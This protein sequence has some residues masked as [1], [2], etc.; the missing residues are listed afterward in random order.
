MTTLPSSSGWGSAARTPRSNS[1]SPSRKEGAPGAG[2][3]GRARAGGGGRPGAPA[4][5]PPGGGPRPA[6]A[7]PGHEPSRVVETVEAHRLH[8]FDQARLLEGRRRPADPAPARAGGGGGHGG[9]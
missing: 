1:A 6:P 2:A 5:G 3:G 9:H 7:R 4:P 8:A